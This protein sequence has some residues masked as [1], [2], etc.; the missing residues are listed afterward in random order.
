MIIEDGQTGRAAIVD[1]E[2]RLKT[3][4]ITQSEDKHTN[5]EGEYNSVYFK[6]TPTGAND[7]FFYLQNTG[8]D[9]V[10]ITDIRISS[11]VGSEIL[12]H[13]VSGTASS[14]TDSLI[15]NR[16][17]GSNKV[18]A[19]TAIHDPDITGLTSEG[20]LLFDEL[21]VVDEMHHMKTTSNI[22]IPQGQ[23]IALLRVAA[24]GL[25]TCLV[26][27]TKAVS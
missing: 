19:I 17:L 10:T 6:V 14:G 7:Y 1:D 16:N 22:I 12:L 2:F 25:I 3:F 5:I 24:T 11:S 18:P 13:K 26:S 9:D 21:S 27:V 20:V 8:V 23:S 15:T 4:S